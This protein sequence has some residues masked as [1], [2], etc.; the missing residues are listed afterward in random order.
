MHVDLCGTV[1]TNPFRATA[2]TNTDHRKVTTI[3]FKLTNYKI[4]EGCV[5]ISITIS[6]KKE[7]KPYAVCEFI[8]RE[9]KERIR[10]TYWSQ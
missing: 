6:R 3:E 1:K 2:I 8:K 7:R 4:R 10:I 9:A 5:R